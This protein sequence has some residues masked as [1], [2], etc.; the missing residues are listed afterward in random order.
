VPEVA[1]P[2][3]GRVAELGAIDAA[4]DG[5]QA[6]LLSGE[7]GIGKTRLL[8]AL[9]ARA[10]ARGCLVLSGSASEL[11]DDLPFWIFVDALEEHVAGFDA[12]RLDAL[13][14]GVAAELAHVLPALTP[15]ERAPGGTDQRYRAHGA[16]RALLE[17]L[18]AGAPL[19]LVLDDI[20]WADPASVDL[21]AALLRRP[22]AGR[23]VLAMATRPRQ[24]PDGSHGP[25]S[26][27]SAAAPSAVSISMASTARRRAN[28]SAL[29]STAPAPTRSSPR[30]AA[31]RSTW[32]SSPARRAGPATRW[33]CAASTCPRRSWRRSAKSSHG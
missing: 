7:P 24:E 31:T 19:V 21:L 20:H 26:A 17:R 18:A 22:P 30:A 27:R 3:V 10:T 5:G 15:R 32:S 8:G 23:V 14:D 4:L 1:E 12:R 28:C 11:E 33:R 2:L 25:T 9:T 13:G 6:L 16:V 29:R